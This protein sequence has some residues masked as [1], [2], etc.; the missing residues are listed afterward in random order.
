MALQPKFVIALALCSLVIRS[1]SADN[2]EWQPIAH[3]DGLFF[4]TEQ[5][6]G[7]QSACIVRFREDKKLRRTVSELAITYR[8]QQAE[9]SQ[10]YSAHFEARDTDTLYLDSCELVV[11]VIA[12]KMQRR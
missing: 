4:K 7:G 12:I 10:N 3:G 11:N 1:A 8:F 2:R 9:H 6:K 5:Q